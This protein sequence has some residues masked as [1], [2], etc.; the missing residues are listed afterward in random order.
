MSG[1][2]PSRAGRAGR[3]LFS[4]DNLPIFGHLVFRVEELLAC[5]DIGPNNPI[6]RIGNQHRRH[7]VPT[8]VHVGGVT[9]IGTWLLLKNTQ[10]DATGLPAGSSYFAALLDGLHGVVE[11]HT[12]SKR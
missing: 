12:S 9:I 7:Q 1:T 4:F 10:L 6:R 11:C 8:D 3:L 5:A 2:R